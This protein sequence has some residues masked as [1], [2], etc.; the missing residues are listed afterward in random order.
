MK[1]KI[2]YKNGVCSLPLSAV[3]KSADA[4]ISELRVLIALCSRQGDIDISTLAQLA[5]C[6]EEEAKEAISFWRGTGLV[7]KE[8]GKETEPMKNADKVSGSKNNDNSKSTE[9]SPTGKVKESKKLRSADELPKYTSDELSNILES[10]K[11]TATLINEC[12]NIMG[13]VFNV[14]E[15]NILMGLVDYLELDCEYIMILLTYCVSI[16]KKTLHYVE[17]T[18]FAFYDM[19]IVEASQLSEELKRREAADAVEGQIRSLFGLGARA[20]TTKEKKFIFSWIN[21]MGYSMEI[22]KKAYELTADAT[23]NASMPYAN[24]ILERWNA[25]GLRSVEEIEA[26]YKK[27]DEGKAH[28]GS[29]DTDL[30]FE[31]AVR[32]SLGED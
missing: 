14:R 1:Y 6:S 29:F 23:G 24:S 18:A 31:A 5:S 9:E 8:S 25:A 28:Q 3:E 19:G 13:K 2:N 7:E 4:G 15:I 11:E 22:I 26:S 10:R 21:D 16:G 12:Q 20:F 17:K 27:N 30:F 32:R